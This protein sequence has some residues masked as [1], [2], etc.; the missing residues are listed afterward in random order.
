M[1]NDFDFVKQYTCIY[2]YICTSTDRLS[3]FFFS[4][5]QDKLSSKFC[6]ENV[7]ARLN[8]KIENICKIP[9]SET[10]NHTLV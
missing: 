6:K 8:F 10:R 7:L 4:T 5:F 9:L 3:S 2:I 1:Y